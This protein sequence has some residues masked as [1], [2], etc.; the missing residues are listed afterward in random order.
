MNPQIPFGDDVISRIASSQKRQDGPNILRQSMVDCLN[1]LIAGASADAR[2]DSSRIVDVTAVGNTAMHHFFVG[3]DARY[4]SMAPYPPVLQSA[5]DFKARD[6]G[7]E[8]GKSAYAHL[9][10][11]KAGFVGSDTVA[12]I[13]ATR[14]HGTKIPTLLIDLGTNGEIVVGNREKL[15]CCS[16][17]AGPAFEGGHIRWGMRAAAGAIEQVKIDPENLDVEVKT[18]EGRK[19]LGLCGSGIISAV[20][21]M[22]RAGIVMAKGNFN[23]KI[24]SPRL[25]KGEEGWEFVLTRAEESGTADNIVI[26][27]KDISELQMAKSAIYA[28]ATLVME[29]FGDE[30]IRRILLAGAGGSTVDPRDART[31]GLFPVSSE[32][33][34]IG[35]GNAAGLGACLALVDKKKR[36]DAQRIAAKTHYH[37]LSGSA[38]FQELFVSSMFFTSARD[39]RDDF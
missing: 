13:L 21:E 4:L 38:R 30:Q 17:A 2:I 34:M 11:L 8:V 7:L 33:E 12:C 6:L 14:L 36:K 9:L 5:Q 10:P 3:L 19:P 25:R 29:L 37:E 32:A 27:Q 18:I 1:G 16:T 26:T 24:Q 39:Y 20:A 15:V 31:I 35:V 23:E 28:G 22:I